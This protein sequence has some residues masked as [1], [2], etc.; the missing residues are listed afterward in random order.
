MKA[1][2]ELATIANMVHYANSSSEV[3]KLGKGEVAEVVEM[4]N[5]QRLKFF[6][7]TPLSCLLPVTM[8]CL[9]LPIL[10]RLGIRL[11]YIC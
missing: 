1:G 4:A 8:V 7:R 2:Q 3:G 11:N 6:P 9:N 5:Q 10:S